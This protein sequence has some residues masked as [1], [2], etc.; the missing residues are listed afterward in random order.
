M[1]CR[2]FEII[3]YKIKWLK[4]KFFTLFRREK[5]SIPVY[6][7]LTEFRN[8]YFNDMENMEDME[9]TS[10]LEDIYFGNDSYISYDNN[11]EFSDI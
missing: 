9:D 4:N 1:T 7:N 11:L 6:E 5:K 8:I 2:F 3:T 10:S